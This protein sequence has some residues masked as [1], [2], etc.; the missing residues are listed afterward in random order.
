NRHGGN[1][2]R[3]VLAKIVPERPLAKRGHHQDIVLVCIIMPRLEK[4]ILENKMNGK[5]LLTERATTKKKQ[6]L[7]YR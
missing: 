5:Y 2:Q 1:E 7:K 4:T 6:I 3:K